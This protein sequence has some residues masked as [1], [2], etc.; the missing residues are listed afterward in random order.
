MPLVLAP[1]K[2]ALQGD[3]EAKKGRMSSL[4]RHMRAFWALRQCE[5][6]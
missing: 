5:L 2:M 3:G 4:W 1:V 6:V